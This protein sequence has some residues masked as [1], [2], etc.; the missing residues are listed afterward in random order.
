LRTRFQENDAG[1]E[2]TKTSNVQDQ[3]KLENFDGKEGRPLTAKETEQMRAAVGKTSWDVVT[4]V[5]RIAYDSSRAAC[6]LHHSDGVMAVNR[7][8]KSLSKQ[9]NRIFMP[10]KEPN[11]HVS[12]LAYSDAVVTG[13]P[14]GGWL[15]FLIYTKDRFARPE[16]LN[17]RK[18]RC[19]LIA[20]K[21][22]P[23]RR[24]VRSSKSAELFVLCDCISELADYVEGL[25]LLGVHL[26][27][28][29]VACDN[30]SVVKAVAANGE[31]NLE[32]KRLFGAVVY[33]SR[34]LREIDA[35]L[36]HV[37]GTANFAD[38]LTRS[39][40]IEIPT[41]GEMRIKGLRTVESA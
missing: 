5:P 41:E 32:E 20:W 30:E 26:H 38:R 2:L 24:A 8:I 13:R 39:S 12:I 25:R 18:T 15:I 7:A 6:N 11:E 29:V 17:S 35:K 37:P 16:E 4:V 14:H 9:S 34:A 40:G 22:Y 33:A 1:V 27:Q 31:G 21:S 36:V 23:V 10:F 19:A 28:I 3:I